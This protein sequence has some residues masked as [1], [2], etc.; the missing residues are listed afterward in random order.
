MFGTQTKLAL[1]NQCKLKD[2]H[3]FSGI[4][5]GVEN[6][7][8]IYAVKTM[9]RTLPPGITVKCAEELSPASIIFW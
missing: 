4:Y 5:F 3:Q 1:T 2:K 8:A 6:K 7:R 9:A